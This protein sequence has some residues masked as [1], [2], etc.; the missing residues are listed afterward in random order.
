MN[1]LDNHQFIIILFRVQ[2]FNGLYSTLN[3]IQKVNKHDF[4]TLYNLYS[5]TLDLKA[6]D[7]NTTEII[8]I[9][10]SYKIIPENNLVTKK[11]KIESKIK[12]NNNIINYKFAGYNLPKTMDNN[13]FGIIINKNKNLILI[14]KPNSSFIY[15]IETFDNHNKIQLLNKGQII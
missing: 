2:Y 1:K 6:E 10:F 8:N 13:K 12:Q 5:S 11:S 7:Y 14:N 3:N 9:I 4:E 15:R